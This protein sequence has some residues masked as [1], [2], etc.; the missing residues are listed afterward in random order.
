MTAPAMLSR[1][2]KAKLTIEDFVTLDRSG[3]FDS[4]SKT[5]LING[6]IYVVNAQYSAH[7]KAKVRLLRRLADACDNLGSGLEAWSE[8]S[9]EL[10]PLSMPEPDI[11]VTR[12]TPGEGTVRGE[13][14]A[15]IVEVSD[16]TLKFDLGKK[17]MLYASQG[18]PEY[19]VADLVA[20]RIV[21]MWA[22][23]GEGYARRDE[24]AFGARVESATIAG[25][26]VETA[27][28]K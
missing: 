3:A 7:M 27:G 18:V 10:K 17:A 21:R 25:L 20:Q 23:E 26:G 13:T 14:V 12:E 22:P 19:W 28:L 16:T 4:Y 2:L 24:W 8:G 5:E 6:V 1:P 9:V 15:L 11:L